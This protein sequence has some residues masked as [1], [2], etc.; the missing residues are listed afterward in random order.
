MKFSFRRIC[1]PTTECSIGIC[2]PVNIKFKRKAYEHCT[3]GEW[4]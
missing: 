3:Q 2:D 1:N 4:A